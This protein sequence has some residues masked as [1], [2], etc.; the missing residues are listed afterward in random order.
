MNTEHEM[1]LFHWNILEVW[2]NLVIFVGMRVKAN[3]K[4]TY[5]FRYCRQGAIAF[6]TNSL[7]P[8][9]TPPHWDKSFVW[10]VVKLFLLSW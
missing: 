7:E 3:I 6:A 10:F 5:V 9:L 2:E 1:I 8:R 4:S